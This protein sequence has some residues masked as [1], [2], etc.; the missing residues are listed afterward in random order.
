[1]KLTTHLHLVLRSRIRGAIP[2]L[3]QY[4]FLPWRLVKHRDIFTLPSTFNILFDVTASNSDIC[5]ACP[6]HIEKGTSA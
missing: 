3:P 5:E 6:L 4:V 2:P 1:V